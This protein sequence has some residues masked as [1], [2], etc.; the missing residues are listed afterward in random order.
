ME[1]A[2]FSGKKGSLEPSCEVNRNMLKSDVDPAILLFTGIRIE[3]Y[4]GTGVS[5]RLFL[6]LLRV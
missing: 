5:G 2:R 6:R 1:R 4:E 3:I